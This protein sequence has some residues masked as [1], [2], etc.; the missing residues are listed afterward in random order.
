VLDPALNGAGEKEHV[1]AA[2]RGIGP[3]YIHLLDDPEVR[4]WYDNLSQGSR[5]TAKK[6]L[7]R[8]GFIRA[9]RRTTRRLDRAVDRAR[10][11]QL[12]EGPPLKAQH[13]VSD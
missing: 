2:R 4:G 5:I 12:S 13:R 3:K 11:L 7:R 6:Y 8:L 9:P 10:K 1:E